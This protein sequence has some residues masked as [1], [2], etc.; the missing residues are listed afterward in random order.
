MH[1][2][3]M[4]SPIN[5]SFLLG[6]STFLDFIHHLVFTPLPKDGKRLSFQNTEFLSEYK[7]TDKLQKPNNPKHNTPLSK[8]FRINS[9]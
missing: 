8:P 2:I 6:I 1:V 3:R 5:K 9:F 7:M 4:E